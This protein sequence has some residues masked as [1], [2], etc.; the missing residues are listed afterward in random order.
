MTYFQVM[1]FI[2]SFLII[3]YSSKFKNSVWG[4]GPRPWPLHQF[5]SVGVWFVWL[6]LNP[7]LSIL[8]WYISSSEN[9]WSCPFN[10]ISPENRIQSWLLL[11]GPDILLMTSMTFSY[12]SIVG[13]AITAITL[14][15]QLVPSGIEIFKTLYVFIAVQCIWI[16]ASTFSH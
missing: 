11:L 16:F 13:F 9:I 12:Q 14:E 15:L 7:P 4:L 1:G 3:N 8:T 2:R 5:E 10:H 6:C